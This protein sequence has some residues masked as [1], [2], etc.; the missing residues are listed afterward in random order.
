MEQIVS[1]PSSP[2]TALV[3]GAGFSRAAAPSMPLT[4][5]LGQDAL[6]SLR[7]DPASTPT[8]ASEGLTF[9]TW[10]SWLAERQPADSEAEYLSA[11]ARFSDLSAAIAREVR[12]AQEKADETGMAPWLAQLVD[13]AHW[14]RWDLVTVNYDTLIEG[15]VRR[16]PRF[17]SDSAIA[18]DDVV[19]GIPNSHAMFQAE[20][21]AY[22]DRETL[23][24]HKL[25]GSI[26][27]YAVPG[28]ASG[29]TFK[30]L[31]FSIDHESSYAA[32]ATIGGREV[33]IVPPTSAKG[34]YFENPRTRFVWREARLGLEKAERIVLIGY[35]IPLTDTAMMNLLARALT[36][37]KELVVVNPDANA[38][39][40]RLRALGA[41]SPVRLL[42]G[43]DCVARFVAEEVERASAQ[44]M[45][46]LLERLLD[47]PD[48][49]VAV[50]W[51]H[52]SWGAISSVERRDDDQTLV[53]RV[54]HLG[55]PAGSIGRPPRTGSDE[56]PPRTLALS[57]VLD[58]SS[59]PRRIIISSE[60][61]EWTVGARV[62]PPDQIDD[63]WI[64]L[65]PLGDRPDR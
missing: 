4:D 59:P 40:D 45:P 52:G 36:A 39:A 43:L 57:E 38:V 44:L 17:D 42:G 20:T 27:W 37:D 5:G 18:V 63:D 1:P 15:A 60:G 49:P 51:D 10:L 3:L 30:R 22:R 28:D 35:S 25:H 54:E 64:V 24:P 12:V 7:W 48:S 33:F 11:R 2:V 13:L 50:G 41:T 31:D 23:R 47:S 34:G 9:E 62:A 6:A 19:T 16:S 32:R 61:R 55:M 46:V 8:F 29:I 58:A 65:R 21:T 53:L 26:D 14:G 56:Y